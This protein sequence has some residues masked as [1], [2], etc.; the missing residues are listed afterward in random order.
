MGWGRTNTTRDQEYLDDG[1]KLLGI[2]VSKSCLTCPLAVCKYDS[3]VAYQAARDWA[4]ERKTTF[5]RMFVANYKGTKT[6]AVS[7]CARELGTTPR[8]VWRYLAE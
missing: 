3:A 7:A 5:A 6:E 4:M 2:E 8:N 1:C